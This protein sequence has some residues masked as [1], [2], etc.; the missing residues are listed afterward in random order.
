M[1]FNV[2]ANNIY[3]YHFSR[4]RHFVLTSRNVPPVFGFLLGLLFDIFL[5]KRRTACELQSVAT[6]K[7][8]L[9]IVTA[10]RT[11]NPTLKVVQ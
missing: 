10:V 1:L 4:L 9:L 11:S 3:R 7:T 6:Q 2:K 8:M 5:P